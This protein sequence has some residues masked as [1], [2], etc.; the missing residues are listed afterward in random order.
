[1]MTENLRTINEINLVYDDNAGQIVKISDNSKL[2][3]QQMSLLEGI[4]KQF[5]LG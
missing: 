4:I 1:M 2:L 3:N 5:S